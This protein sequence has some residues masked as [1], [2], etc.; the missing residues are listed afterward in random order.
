VCKNH[1]KIRYPKAIRKLR[2]SKHAKWK[3]LK[4]NPTD[5]DLKAIYKSSAANLK[6]EIWQWH[7]DHETKLLKNMSQSTF[8]KYTKARLKNNHRTAV[9]MNNSGEIISNPIDVAN[10]FNKYFVST[11]TSD[12]NILPRF[13]PRCHD[14]LNTILFDVLSVSNVIKKLKPSLSF[15]VDS[16]PNIFLRKTVTSITLPL[17]ILFER[18]MS[19]NYIPPV[20]KMAKIIPLHKKGSTIEVSNYRPISLVSSIS[21]VMERV[22]VNQT[23]GFLKVHSLITPVQYGFQQ[24]SSTITQLI[25]CHSDWIA[26]QNRG[27]STD[28]IYLDYAKAFDSVIHEKLLLKLSSYGI[29]NDLLNWFRNFL[30]DRTQAVY[31]EGTLS[32]FLPVVSGVPQGSVCAPL[33]FLIY[34]NDLPE[35]LPPSVK[36]YLFADD[37]KISNVIKSIADCIILQNILSS[38]SAW[39]E[40]WQLTL[41]IIKCIVQH[42]G[43]ANPRH[44][45][46]VSNISLISIMF[47]ISVSQSVKT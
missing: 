21:K 2:A 33:M 8:F 26:T 41:S 44:V 34:I 11:F 27:D 29:H 13:P 3:A 28:V 36:C 5:S 42:F 20:W 9:L 31:I 46:L 24:R 43:R 15:G 40:M 10:E 1:K 22:N 38:I 37:A 6:K 45:Y 32:Q 47:K 25:E 23:L 19:A 39:S 30:S 4:S 17:S 12:N 7:R 35:Q 16:I 14:E 18:S